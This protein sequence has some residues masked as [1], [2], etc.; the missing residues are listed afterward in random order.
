MHVEVKHGGG[1]TPYYNTIINSTIEMCQFLNGT[2]SNPIAKW[3]IDAVS[4]FVPTGFFHPC[5]YVGQV[6][7]SNV[8]VAS[9]RLFS[10]FLRGRYKMFVRA[11]DEKDENIITFK[12]GIEL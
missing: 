9:L 2:D 8:S 5:P 10:Q 12:L 7:C 4:D 1:I 3:M 11:F 6:K